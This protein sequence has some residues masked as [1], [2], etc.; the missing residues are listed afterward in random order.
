LSNR[1]KGRRKQGQSGV[2]AVFTSKSDR[3]GRAQVIFGL[4]AV[5]AGAASW[6]YTTRTLGRA[7]LDSPIPWNASASAI[8]LPISIPIL[9][10]GVGL[11]T[12]Y[13]AMKGTW[14]AS[15]R[16]ELA[17]LELEALVGQKNAVSNPWHDPSDIPDGKRN[18]RL[19]SDFLSGTLAI[20][21]VEA[22]VLLIIYGGLVK[23]YVSNVNMQ[24]W[25]QSNFAPGTYL[26]NY[27]TVLICAGLLG[28]LIFRLQPRKPQPREVRQLAPSSRAS[29]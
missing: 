1:V 15:N 23:E 5:V 21:L 11:C 25:V 4:A 20:A 9:I 8:L 2:Q 10:G 19:Q 27:Y 14:R 22:A 13:L 6:T 12:Y 26:L 24:N 29:D 28:M 3:R 7:G 16:I 18:R 17:L